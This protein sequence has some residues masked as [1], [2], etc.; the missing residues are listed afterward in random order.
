ML[1]VSGLVAIPSEPGLQ[2]TTTSDGAY[3]NF[4]VVSQDDKKNIHRYL[5]ELYVPTDEITRWESKII[6]GNVFLIHNAKWK[7]IVKEEW[8]YP[9]PR[10]S[11]NRFGFKK[12]KT[13]MWIDDA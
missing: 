2:V 12:L 7:M 11:L 3:L 8:K 13:A 4:V 10:L 6:T 9:L 1:D 5:A